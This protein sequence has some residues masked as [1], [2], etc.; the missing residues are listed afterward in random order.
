[1]IQLQKEFKLKRES[2][3]YRGLSKKDRVKI[4]LRFAKE[5]DTI[6]SKLHQSPKTFPKSLIKSAKKQ[7]G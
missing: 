4:E 2:Q 6:A 5:N 1:M 3:S 7:Q